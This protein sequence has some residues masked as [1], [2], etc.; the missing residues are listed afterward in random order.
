MCDRPSGLMM[1]TNTSSPAAS[2]TSLPLTKDA[3]K[4]W[5]QSL[6]GLLS[7]TLTHLAVKSKVAPTTLTKPVNKDVNYTLSTKTLNKVIAGARLIA[8]EKNL[9]PALDRWLH[10]GQ[11]LTPEAKEQIAFGAVMRHLKLLGAFAAEIQTM[12]REFGREIDT[13]MAVVWAGDEVR[14]I[15]D[16]DWPETGGHEAEE[17]ALKKGFRNRRTAIASIIRSGRYGMTELKKSA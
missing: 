4:L 16:S 15:I 9:L 14:T 11:Q 1:R 3:Q 10:S 6:I 5:L 12:G 13:E 7:T 2:E 17:L 8:A